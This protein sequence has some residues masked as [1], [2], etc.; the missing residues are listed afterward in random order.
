MQSTNEDFSRIVTDGYH[1][2]RGWILIAGC[3]IRYAVGKEVGLSA[4]SM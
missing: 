3:Y 2:A 4:R 1:P